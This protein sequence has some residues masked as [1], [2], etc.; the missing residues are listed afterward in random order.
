MSRTRTV[1]LA[2]LAAVLLVAAITLAG[3]DRATGSGSGA[4]DNGLDDSVYAAALGGMAA[5]EPSPGPD[6]GPA[7]KGRPGMRHHMGM[8]H[9]P[10]MG[11][12]L[13]GWLLRGEG[14]VKDRDGTF[15]TVATQSG[16]VTA[17][18]GSSVTIRS[19][20]GYSRTW[21]LTDDTKYWSFGDQA[22]KA[23]L[24]V[25]VDVRVAGPVVDGK[26][27][28]RIVLFPPKPG[29]FPHRS[30]DPR[31]EGSDRPAPSPSAST[32]SSTTTA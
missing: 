28:A 7:G 26:A 22:S 5:D 23:D 21:A 9:G 16:E 24:K 2:A 11:L 10:L 31:P 1:V 25:G 29:S 19:E 32:Q 8:R 18:D 14:V 15:V 17:V 13:G 4:G 30:H 20:D 6:D 3:S 27:T 12:G